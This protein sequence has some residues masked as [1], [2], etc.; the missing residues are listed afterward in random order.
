SAQVGS[1]LRAQKIDEVVGGF[2]GPLHR[3]DYFGEELAALGDLDGD[4]IG[5]LAVGAYGDD[6]GGLDRGAIWI[7]FLNANGTVKSQSKISQTQ[8]GFGGTLPDGAF[9][10]WKLANV[11]DLDGDGAPELAVMS[12]RGPRLWILFLKPDG[13]VKN[14][15]LN[16]FSDPV[17]V[18]VA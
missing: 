15:T 16:L 4:G 6:D 9:L 12:L 3:D 7:L 2:S 10:G 11:G 18:P 8:G 17:F 1:V 14:Q 5:D 13:T